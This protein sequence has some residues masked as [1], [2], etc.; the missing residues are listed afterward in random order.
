MAYLIQLVYLTRSTKVGGLEFVLNLE[1]N[2]TEIKATDA[3]IEEQ[4]SELVS[5]DLKQ[6]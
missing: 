3:F 6:G 5:S 4:L 1:H 2:I